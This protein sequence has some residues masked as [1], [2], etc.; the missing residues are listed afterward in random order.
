LST[1]PV[2]CSHFTLGNPKSHFSTLLFIYFRL[3]TLP[4]KK[5]SNNCC[6]AALAVYLLFNASYNL[7]SR[8]T[9]YGARYRRSV[10][11]DMDVEAC[12]SGLLR[13][14]LNFST[15]WCNTRLISVEKDWK[16]V[17]MQKVVT[18]NSCCDIAC[19]TFRLPYFTT[20]SF[21][22][23][24][25]QPTNGCFQSLQRLKKKRNKPSVR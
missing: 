17:L 3:F 14:G 20:G 25:R 6:I 9:A 11:I 7:H 2:R 23:H 10:C 24:R 19:L 12:G 13:H 15:A 22:S 8:T 4:Q 5:T 16:H 1:S 18:L 21:Q